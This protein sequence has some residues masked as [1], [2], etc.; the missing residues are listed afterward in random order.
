MRKA[1]LVTALLGLSLSG[2]TYTYPVAHPL[3]DTVDQVNRLALD[4]SG[5][6]ELRSGLSFPFTQLQV[7]ADSASWADLEAGER[8]AVTTLDIDRIVVQ[9]RERGARQGSGLGFLLGTAGA[10]VFFYTTSTDP[11]SGAIP[12][13]PP[14]LRVGY[15]ESSSASSREAS[16]EARISS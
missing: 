15:R 12:S 7:N 3:T 16:G 2:C 11:C 14:A 9:R 1:A 6:I 4:R 10:W 13:W 8:R 5:R